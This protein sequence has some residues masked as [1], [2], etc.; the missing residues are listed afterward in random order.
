MPDMMSPKLNMPPIMY[1][2]NLSNISF[3]DNFFCVKNL[4][5]A[6]LIIGKIIPITNT[7]LDE[8]L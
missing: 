5:K 3:L 7:I 8:I 4:K 1:T 6:R 2:T